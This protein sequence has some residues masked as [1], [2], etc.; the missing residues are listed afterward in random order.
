[1]SEELKP[2]VGD[3]WKMGHAPLVEII[4]ISEDFV[5]YKDFGENSKRISDFIKMYEIA[6]RDGKPYK[7]KR[8][9]E[10]GAFYPVVY[11]G[12][13][14]V[15]LYEY[16]ELY[17]ESRFYMTKSMGFMGK[18]TDFDCIGDKLEIDWPEV[19]E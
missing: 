12:H 15:A 18:E 9:F 16:T 8:V 13:K 1:M 10:N 5:I 7:P 14:D 11:Q 6:E 2:Q 3:V 4:C 17:E 19:A